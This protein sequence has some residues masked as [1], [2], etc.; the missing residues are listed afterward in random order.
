MKNSA[1][2][3]RQP[4]KSPETPISSSGSSLSSSS[5]FSADKIE[6]EMLKE[7]QHGDKNG[8]NKTAEARALPKQKIN[9]QLHNTF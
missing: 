2:R 9:E 8:N 7:K 4:K 3:K 5:S 1:S 6:Q